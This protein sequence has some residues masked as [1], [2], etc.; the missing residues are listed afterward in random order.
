MYM[1]CKCST[2]ELHVLNFHS[3]FIEIDQKQEPFHLP[4]NLHFWAENTLGIQLKMGKY[5]MANRRKN[6]VSGIILASSP[7]RTPEQPHLRDF[8]NSMSWVVDDSCSRKPLDMR[9]KAKV[10]EAFLVGVLH[11]F[12]CFFKA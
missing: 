5:K 4:V 10:L 3:Y 6:Q 11:A 8:N 7:A 9:A 1:P 2:S 12:S